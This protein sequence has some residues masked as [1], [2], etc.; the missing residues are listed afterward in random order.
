MQTYLI[1]STK[2]KEVTLTEEQICSGVNEL[3]MPFQAHSAVKRVN[4]C[5]NDASFSFDTI[6]SFAKF[7]WPLT[8]YLSFY[9]DTNNNLLIRDSSHPI[10]RKVINGFING[11]EGHDRKIE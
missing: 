9:L 3:A 2:I 5:E 6:I 4:R 11:I 1:A 8:S 10:H 7:N